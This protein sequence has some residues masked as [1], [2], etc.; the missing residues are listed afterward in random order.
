MERTFAMIKPDA[1]GRGLVGEC[2]RRFERR[3]LKIVGMKMQKLSVEQ[4][5]RHYGEHEGRPY[6]EGLIA[7]IT[8][9]PTVQLVIEGRDAVTQVRRMNGATNCLDAAPGTIRGDFGLSNQKNL[10]HAA[11]SVE[12]A[13]RE[14]ALY[15]DE[16]ELVEYTL[17]FAQWLQ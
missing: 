14:M 7:F 6:F 15:F 13:A 11:D 16:S 8:S 5:Y 17:P 10:I 4:A 12:T 1:V 2:L 9:G 3:G